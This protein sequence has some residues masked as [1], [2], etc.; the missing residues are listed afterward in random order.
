MEYFG[1][2]QEDKILWEYFEQHP[3]K[4][5]YK[6][7][8]DIGANDG[9]TL[10][11]THLFALNG[12]GGVCVE[13]DVR[14]FYRLTGLYR[15]N[16]NVKLRNCAIGAKTENVV[17]HQSSELLKQGDI[18]LVSTTKDNEIKRFRSTVNYEP[19]IVQCYDWADFTKD[20]SPKFSLLSL[21]AEGCDWEILQQID[22]S[23]VQAVCVEWNGVESLAVLYTD[24]CEKFGLK[25]HHS[26]LENLIF[27]R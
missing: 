21:D 15:N 8:L 4:K 25:P 20:F 10:S 27:V 24:Y 3:P 11:N 14:A 23:K 7:F 5:G 6:N 1:Q 13:P 12:W 17:L 18:G 19:L 9:K 2:N 22:L 16:D 26:N